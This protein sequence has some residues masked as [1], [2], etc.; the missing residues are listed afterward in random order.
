MAGIRPAILLKNRPW[1]R[2]FPMDFLKFLRTPF[3]IEHL[4]GGCCCN[5]QKSFTIFVKKLRPICWQGPKSVPLFSSAN[6]P[7]KSSSQKVFHFFYLI[8]ACTMA[9]CNVCHNNCLT[10]LCSSR[11]SHFKMP[12]AFCNKLLSH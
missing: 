6:C 9:A 4:S 7:L 8:T 11:L 1:H 2:Y 12:D 3:F 5:C 10:L